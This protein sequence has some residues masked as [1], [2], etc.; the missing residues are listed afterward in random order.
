MRLAPFER[1]QFLLSVRILSCQ[2]GLIF[3][4]NIQKHRNLK[5]FIR[6]YNTKIEPGNQ[7]TKKSAVQNL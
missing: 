4:G 3:G 7:F 5:I 2:F 6:S 1:A